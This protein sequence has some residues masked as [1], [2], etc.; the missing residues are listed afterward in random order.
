MLDRFPRWFGLSALVLLAALGIYV[1]IVYH[2]ADGLRT[3][4]E[5]SSDVVAAS[6]E[7]ERAEQETLAGSVVSAAQALYA[8]RRLESALATIDASPDPRFRAESRWMRQQYTSATGL[9]VILQDRQASERSRIILGRLRVTLSELSDTAV[10]MYRISH[11]ARAR[12][13]RWLFLTELG[14]IALAMVSLVALIGLYQRYVRHREQAERSLQRANESLQVHAD[15]KDQ[16]LFAASHDLK[17]PLRMVSTYLD[18]IQREL[19]ADASAKIQHYFSHVQ[20]GAGRMRRLLD[21]LYSA[22]MAERP[23]DHAE[24]FDL[25]AETAAIGNLL[26]D[27]LRDAGGSLTIARL[28]RVRGDRAR[29]AQVLQN[30]ISNAIKY[31]DPARPLLI[32][33]E[34]VEEPDRCT[35]CVRDNGQGIASQHHLEIFRLFKRLHGPE[36]DGTGAGLAICKRIVESWG[37]RIWVESTAGTGSTFFFTIPRA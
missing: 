34:V 16:F 26:G 4:V 27:P 33:V 31:R 5:A 21:D 24:D 1:G 14:A 9:Q 10:M 12:S 18:L 8:D 19:G 29:V 28:P 13:V 20:D 23:S 17:Q 3:V 15:E 6:F 2:Q 11:D 25:T 30:L 37:G 7:I 35:V 32:A 22:T 36:I